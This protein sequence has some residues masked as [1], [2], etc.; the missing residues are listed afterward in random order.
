MRKKVI[1]PLLALAFAASASAQGTIKIGA[2]T[3]L[4]GRFATFGQMQQAGFKVAIE[5]INAKGG[6]NGQKLELVLQ[7][8]AS[9]TNKALSAAEN[10]V[11]QHVPLIL[12]AYASGI[13]K[14]LSQYMNRVKVPLLNTTSVDETITKPGNPYTF[15]VTNQSSVYTRSLI[16]QLGKMQ[17]LKTVAVLTSNDAF[18]KSVMNDVS[19]LL[20]KSGYQLIG[21][22]TY[23]QGLTDFRPIL[24]RYKAANPDVVIFASYEQDAVALAKQVKEVGLAPKIIAG[25]ATGFALPDFLKGAGSSAEG[26]L[27]TMVWNQDVKYPGAQNLYARLKKALGGEEP[28][29]HAAQSYAGML[30]AAEAIRLAGGTDPAKVRDALTKVKLNTAFGP[31]SFKNYGGY[32][33]QNSVVGLI[34]QVQSGKFVTVA[35]ATAATGKLI[36]KR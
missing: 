21:K 19:S 5:E 8:D 26:F 10:L 15:R 36:I 30:A 23:D 7:D 9:D 32:Q 4:S 2:I 14:P 12:G 24:N 18:G 13:T 17:G 11:N 35:P 6:V 16:E 1:F 33:N 27:V 3:S 31:V 20:P 29:Q 28:S 25:I 22:D 34:T